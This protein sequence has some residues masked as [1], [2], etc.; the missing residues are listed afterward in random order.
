MAQ[1]LFDGTMVILEKALDL[2][3]MKHNLTVSNI[4]NADTPNYKAFDTVVEEELG[5]LSGSDKTVELKRTQ[6]RHLPVGTTRLSNVKSRFAAEPQL[7]RKGDGN[8]VD[9]DRVMANLTENNLMYS[10]IAQII[11]KKFS[12]LKDVIQGGNR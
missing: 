4:A 10:A 5:K 2:R 7:T 12:G 8:T 3:S 1:G 6:P 11:S 9:F